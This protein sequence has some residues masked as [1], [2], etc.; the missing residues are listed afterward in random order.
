MKYRGPGFVA[1]VVR[2]G[3]S[4]IPSTPPLPSVSSTQ[5]KTKKGRRLADGRAGKGLGEEPNHTTA[6]FMVKLVRFFQKQS[7]NGLIFSLNIPLC[8]YH[9]CL[10]VF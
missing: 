2:L 4:L 8:H 1:G 7:T 6:A 5:T 3:S 9:K 10:T